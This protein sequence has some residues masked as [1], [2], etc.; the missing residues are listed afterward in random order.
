MS[1][2]AQTIFHQ[3]TQSSDCQ[4]YQGG[5]QFTFKNPL[6]DSTSSPTHI[7]IF[8][9]T[10]FKNPCNF[11][12]MRLPFIPFG[13]LNP[14]K[15][16]TIGG[17]TAIGSSSPANP[18]LHIYEPLSITNAWISDILIEAKLF[19]SLNTSCAHN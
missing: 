12:K 9:Q 15:R 8:H 11:H 2:H 13:F 19:S 3:D 5:L 4:P 18:P 16:P 10:N 17:K 6:L 7:S 14:P 1:S